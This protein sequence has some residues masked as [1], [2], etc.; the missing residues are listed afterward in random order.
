MAFTKIDSSS[1]NGLPESLW[2]R[3]LKSFGAVGNG[4][5]DDTVA[6]ANALAAGVPLTGGKGVYAVT[7]KISLPSNCSLW[8]TEFKQLAPGASL[9]V[10]TL[11]ADTKIN[12]DLRRVKVNRNGDGT[13]GGL[14]NG[15]GGN[16]GALNSA[17]G[18]KFVACSSCHF[19]D[20]EVY[21]NDSGTG[22]LFEQ[23]GESSRI[24]RPYVH[25][26]AW[27]RTAATD[28]Q[29]Q[30]IWLNNCTRIDVVAPRVINLPGTLNGVATIRFSRCIAVGGGTGVRILYPYVETADQ[31]VDLTG[32]AGN[33]ECIV[34]GGV[35]RNIYIWGFKLANS[36]IRCIISKCT[37]YNCGVGFV[38]SGNAA[39]PVDL[40]TDNSLFVDCVSRNSGASGQA[41]VSVAGFRV[42][43]N[44]TS[45]ASNIKFIRC[46]AIDDQTVKTM[47]HGF[48]SEVAGSGF[49]L[50]VDCQSIGHIT[51][52]KLGTFITPPSFGTVS[53]SGGFQTGDIIERGSNGNGNYI[54]F[55]DGTQE[56][57]HSIDESATAWA[58]ASGA[59]FMRASAY[60]WTFPAVFS[61]EPVVTGSVSRGEAIA[62]GIHY[63]SGTG[64]TCDVHPWISVSQPGG[65]AKLMKLRAIGRWY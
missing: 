52:S 7:G 48:S 32:S 12:V 31:G 45:A 19:E 34:E 10:I 49:A 26:I 25:D 9:S 15:S 23:I 21:G 59:L 4:T 18:M 64:T 35:A 50:M 53:Q 28:D 41:V 43:G 47:T 1:V 60:Q 51:A 24:I 58:T 8:D 16:N 39:Q 61:S 5:T 42:L 40:R 36:A 2:R 54:R 56:C 27:S 29:V 30:G 17:F 33:K 44:G 3:T 20:L 13:N 46:I 55:A 38:A 37:A 6:V 57:W 65:N 63:R 62:S 14:L 11:E 22:I